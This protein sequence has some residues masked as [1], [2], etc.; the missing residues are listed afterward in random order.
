MAAVSLQRR[1]LFRC[2]FFLLL[3]LFLCC[4]VFFFRFSL[5]FFGISL[6]VVPKLTLAHYNLCP[7]FYSKFASSALEFF[8]YRCDGFSLF[9]LIYTTNNEYIYSVCSVERQYLRRCPCTHEKTPA[10][11]FS[12][13]FYFSSAGLF[14]FLLP[15]YGVYFHNYNNFS[16][17]VFSLRFDFSV[18]LH[19]ESP[20]LVL[21]SG[22]IAV[23]LGCSWAG[24]R[25][26]FHSK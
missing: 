26:L 16:S 23:E 10:A 1:S 24:R 11:T 15:L 12:F 22:F 13:P 4:W 5:Y 21:F 3:S 18:L 17:S 20:L 19:R 2:H 8:I 25:R 6:F 7:V 9:T 14:L